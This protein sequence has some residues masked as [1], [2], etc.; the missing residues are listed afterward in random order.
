M[1]S[2]AV[3]AVSLTLTC[4]PAQLNPDSYALATRAQALIVTEDRSPGGSAS[5]S[6]GRP[7]ICAI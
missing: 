1:L 7:M 2:L 6:R 4:E 3:A 5:V